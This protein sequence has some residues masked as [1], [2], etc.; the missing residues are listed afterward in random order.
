VVHIGELCIECSLEPVFIF[1]V[2]AGVSCQWVNDSQRFL[3]EHF[4]TIQNSPPRY[5]IL[6][7]HFPLPHLGFTS[8]MLQSFQEKLRWSRGSQTD[9][10]DVPV[11]SNQTVTHWP[12]HAG[13]ILLQLV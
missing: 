2:Q 6:P 3:L 1:L 4:D 12:S 7:S 9:G 11:Q 5:T 8:I 13:K 10:E